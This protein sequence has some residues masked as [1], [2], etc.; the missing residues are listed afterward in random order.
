M[1]CCV[2]RAS[3]SDFDVEA[4]L[5]D[6]PLEPCSVWH[7]GETRSRDRVH[8][9][10]G[11]NL[12]IGSGE[13][14]AQIAGVVQFMIAHDVE[15]RRLCSCTSIEIILDFAIARRDVFVQCDSFPATLI[16]LA[17]SLGLGIEL[18]QYPVSE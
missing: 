10:S 9:D 5:D 3:G 6:S 13:V 18:T 15:M 1:L 8:N 16:R 4:F 17:G 7:R 2:L 11:F 12:D 14:S